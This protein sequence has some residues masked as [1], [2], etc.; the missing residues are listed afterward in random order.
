MEVTVIALTHNAKKE[1]WQ[2]NFAVRAPFDFILP[3]VR[4]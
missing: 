2:R 4:A 3:T 1:P